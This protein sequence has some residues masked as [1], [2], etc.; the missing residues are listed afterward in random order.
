[1]ERRV[2]A[3]PARH[4][5]LDE[6]KAALEP[7]IQS[8]VQGAR[9]WVWEP[10]IREAHAAPAKGL[11]PVDTAAV[12][13]RDVEA[14]LEEPGSAARREWAE[15]AKDVRE[16][17]NARLV[18]VRDGIAA[19]QA[20][21]VCPELARGDWL[22]GE[23]LLQAADAEKVTL[24]TL[25]G[26]PVF[27]GQPPPTK[28]LLEETWGRLL[29]ASVK[30][31][32]D[33][34]QAM[35]KQRWWV[36]ETGR[37][38]L[39]KIKSNPK[40]GTRYWVKKYTDQVT[41]FWAGDPLP[42]ASKY[43]SLFKATHAEIDRVVGEALLRQV[44]E[45]QITLAQAGRDK[46]VAEVAAA[47]RNSGAKPE[48]QVHY[49]A[50]LART[51]AA[52]KGHELHGQH[53]ALFEETT[54]HMRGVVQEAVRAQ[55]ERLEVNEK[56]QLAVVNE[57]IRRFVEGKHAEKDPAR[58]RQALEQELRDKGE[59]Q[60]ATTA[61]KSALGKVDVLARVLLRQNQLVDKEEAGVKQKVAKDDNPNLE[62]WKDHYVKLVEAA[63]KRDA[64]YPK[65]GEFQALLPAVTDRIHGI[66]SR[67]IQW[68]VDRIKVI[69]TRQISLVE[70]HEDFV[71]KKISAD[72]KPIHSAYVDLYEKRVEKDWE[73]SANATN[74]SE[75]ERAL[76]RDY[77][78]LLR[79]T[80]DNIRGVVARHIPEQ[81]AASPPAETTVARA[82]RERVTPPDVPKGGS[83]G[84]TTQPGGEASKEGGS[85]GGGSGDGGDGAG[86]G[87]EG[88]GG[89][90]GGGP[91]FPMPEMLKRSFPWLLLLAALLLLLLLYLFLRRKKSNGGSEPEDG[92]GDGDGYTG[93]MLL[94]TYL[95]LQPLFWRFVRLYGC[96]AESILRDHVQ[97]KESENR[98]VRGASRFLAPKENPPS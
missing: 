36:I 53:K 81:P 13:K 88:G 8:G 73:A 70:R 17:L 84:P 27:K 91:A 78:K 90:G 45:A 87:G 65:A 79:E 34:Q 3:E 60:S 40:E 41:E 77:P 22:P 19:K 28:E 55:V 14:R 29:K 57:A 92:V 5:T 76:A 39:P 18:A 80:V 38:L 63:W 58:V 51:T 52:W 25:V 37:T 47:R 23:Q 64:L 86:P 69:L 71:A 7:L 56:T 49:D 61:V 85:G 32:Q 74:L 9:E 46:V 15:L 68:Q 12:L 35:N 24:R 95:R 21:E 83:D 43:K 42:T 30:A 97:Q 10:L 66:V 26:L 48:F 98:V 44:K 54:L 1:M 11:D 6:S 16:L 62:A 94:W 96:K 93:F 33:G 59:G 75:E 72:P 89:G 2:L 50:Y 67:L 82:Q 4:H 20:A 31:I